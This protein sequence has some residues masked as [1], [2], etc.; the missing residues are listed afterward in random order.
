M[1]RL[2]IRFAVVF[3]FIVLSSLAFA[4]VFPPVWQPG[5]F[6]TGTEPV[7]GD[8]PCNVTIPD[9][10]GTIY[11]Y[12]AYRG[13]PV[14]DG[15]VNG[16]PVWNSIPWTAMNQYTINGGESCY[17]FDGACDD[18]ENFWG[19]EDISAYFKV[20][21][22]DDHVYFA[23]YKV[24]DEY[25]YG[26]DRLATNDL[27]N[28]WQDDAY[29]IVLDANSPDDQGGPLPSA[30]IGL[31]LLDTTETAYNSW[32]NTNGDPLALAEGNGS[33]AIEIC[34]GKAFFAK[35]T[36]KHVGYTEVIE[37]AFSK[38]DEIAADTPQMFSI[39]ANDP[40]EIHVVDALEWS[41]GI[42]NG[43]LP[44]R[45]ASIVYSSLE[46]PADPNK[47]VDITDLGG[48]IVGSN[49][50]EPWTG[51]NSDGSPDKE[52]IEKL[53]DNDINTK[54]LVG[55]VESWFDYEINEPALIS[56][57]TITSAND[58]P[59]RDPSTWLL[60]GWDETAKDWVIL[61]DVAGEPSWE[62]RFMT[63]TWT[64]DNKDKWFKKFR[65]EIIE[66][67]NDPEG[68]MQIAEWELLGKLA[69]DVE[70][71]APLQPTEFA[72]RQNYPNP[73]N[74]TTT[75]SYAIQK[76]GPVELRVYDLLGH[77]VAILVNTMQN[78]GDYSVTL[79]ADALSSGVYIY[80]LTSAGSTMSHKMVLMK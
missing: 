43:K 14:V 78:P 49:D 62:N 31:A 46:P 3:C 48:T 57:Y 38:W 2:T 54:Y 27:G 25:V 16:D 4:Q 70:E 63:K 21:W 15:I 37:V 76:T 9:A 64:F 73:F 5:P 39:M 55:A 33:S 36:P 28:I 24:D 75:I 20:L 13:T 52:R 50:D 35:I 67:N 29:Q 58:A 1:N 69:S 74:P 42:F 56:S 79:D 53:I 19:A 8:A 51:P 59:T 68:L 12:T 7:R 66:I 61:H 6:P 41:R 40:D 60:L 77:A 23:L 26:E 17:I 10:M 18:V 47:L 72:L 32:R 44:E 80:T 22:D 30:E 65:F 11:E 45:Y 34:D 71:K